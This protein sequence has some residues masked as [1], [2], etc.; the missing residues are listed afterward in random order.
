MLTSNQRKIVFTCL[1][2]AAGIHRASAFGI[3]KLS[4]NVDRAADFSSVSTVVL[5]NSHDEPVYVTGRPVAWD[6]DVM[7]NMLTSPTADLAISPP[8]VRISGKGAATFTVRYVGPKK[9]GEGA[10]RAVFDEVRVPVIE[11]GNDISASP[12]TEITTGIVISIPVFVSDFADKGVSFKDVTAALHRTESG[13]SIVV[14]NG[15][16]LHVIVESVRQGDTEIKKFHN[17]I[18]AKKDMLFDA[19]K[20]IDF[21]KPIQIDL[22]YG[23]DKQRINVLA[24]NKLPSLKNSQRFDS[25]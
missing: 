24:E 8:V 13:A 4:L 18:F 21:S 3:D 7:G 23:E 6:N 22:S 25:L 9:N 14:K 11:T 15:G 20:G 17:T 16:N 5:F 2:F 1:F 12:M 10:Y 19:L